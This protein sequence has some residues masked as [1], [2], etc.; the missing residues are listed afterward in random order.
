M[1]QLS[2]WT[3][4]RERLERTLIQDIAPWSAQRGAT[5]AMDARQTTLAIHRAQRRLPRRLVCWPL[6]RAMPSYHG[7]SDDL[8]TVR[9]SQC[10]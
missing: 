2:L 4:G 5:L 10:P 8:R 3:T 1:T 6:L 9:G 7:I